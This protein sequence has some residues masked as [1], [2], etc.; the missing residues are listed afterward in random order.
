MDIFHEI[1]SALENE[2]HIMLV[3]ILSTSGST[4]ASALSKMIIKN[5]GTTSVGTIGGG[6][7]EGEVINHANRLYQSNKAKILSFDLNED[8]MESGLICGGSLEVLIEPITRKY[9]PIYQEIKLIRDKGED[10]V[11]GILLSKD[12]VVED[13]VIFKRDIGKFDGW[14]VE[15]FSDIPTLQQSISNAYQKKEIVRLKLESGEIILEPIFSNP[16]LIIFG[17]G[18]V[19]KF[20]SHFAAI[21]GFE[22]T[23]VDDREKYANPNRF[24]EAIY[25]IA[26]DYNSVFD[27]LNVTPSTYIVIVTRGHRYDEIVLEQALKTQAKY[28]GMIGSKHKVFTTFQHLREKGFS[29][30]QLKR[31]HA[32]IGINIGASTTEEIAISIVAEMICIRREILNPPQH[33][34]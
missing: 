33:M 15:N 16:K 8:D 10:C 1:L 26:A 3:T 9:I 4:P 6:C 32:P 19:S 29:E 30:A 31:V 18:H 12:N 17:G 21:V 27:K 11:L 25:T 13:K 34:Y 23:I 2:D 28:I 20:V 24:P 5:G 22:I 7:M 14:D